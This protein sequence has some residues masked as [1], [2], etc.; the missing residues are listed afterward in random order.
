LPP[1]IVDIAVTTLPANQA[2]H[3]EIIPNERCA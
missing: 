1:Q 2:G 3:G